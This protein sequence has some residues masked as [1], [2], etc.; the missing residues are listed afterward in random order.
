VANGPPDW[1]PR[2]PAGYFFLAHTVEKIG[3]ALHEDW[4]GKEAVTIKPLPRNLKDAW[5]I[6][7]LQAEN[8]LQEHRPDLKRPAVTGWNEFSDEDWKTAYELAQRL[9]PQAQLAINRVEAAQSEIVKRSEAG[10]L[11]LK[12]RPVKGGPWRNFLTEWWGFESWRSYFDRCRVDPEYPNGNR[13]GW[14]EDDEH[15]IFVTSESV[16]RVLG[17]LSNN[18]SRPV[19]APIS[20]AISSLWPQGIPRHVRA[21]DRDAKIKQ[22][23]VDKKY[24]VPNSD[25]ALRKAV[26]RALKP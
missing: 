22:Y 24:D 6:N 26:Q 13:P 3:G 20:E 2:E 4:T 21:D 15:W 8:L 11:D 1:W 5:P 9:F 25:G 10:E 23:L 17:Q 18:R 12:I 14:R 19:D 7:L 16:E